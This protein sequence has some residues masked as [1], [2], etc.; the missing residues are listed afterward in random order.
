MTIGIDIN[1][2]MHYALS[3]KILIPNLGHYLPKVQRTYISLECILISDS[4]QM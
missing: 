1:V 2:I 4:S 3:Y